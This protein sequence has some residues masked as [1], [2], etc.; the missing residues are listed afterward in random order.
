[1]YDGILV[2]DIQP[3]ARRIMSTSITVEEDVRGRIET[4]MKTKAG[5]REL[6]AKVESVE[7]DDDM[8]AEA[9]SDSYKRSIDCSNSKRF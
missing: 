7:F 4:L 9:W 8:L 2:E 3:T 6:L 5:F 1:M